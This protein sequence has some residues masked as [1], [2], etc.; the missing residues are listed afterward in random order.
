MAEIIHLALDKNPE[1]LTEVSVDAILLLMESEE[2]NGQTQESFRCLD[3]SL[4]HQIRSAKKVLRD[5]P[6]FIPSMNRIKAPYVVLCPTRNA[7]SLMEKNFETMAMKSI[8]ISSQ[9]GRVPA[10]WC[11]WDPA[12]LE[13]VYVCSENELHGGLVR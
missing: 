10:L 3:W 6:I 5:T 8:A 2:V 4:N 12:Q 1:A 13:S 7:K 9:T 11:Q